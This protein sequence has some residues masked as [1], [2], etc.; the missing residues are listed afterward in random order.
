MPSVIQADLLK[1]ASSSKTLATLSSSAVTLH[2][3]VTVPASIGGSIHYISKA[4]ASNSASI[5][6]TSGITSSFKN[7]KFILNNVLPATDNVNF[8]I[9]ISFDGGSSY[10]TSGYLTTSQISF[11]GS[12]Q[13]H[14]YIEANDSL[15]I[16]GGSGASNVVS[17]GGIWGTLILTV[18]SETVSH[19]MYGEL[20]Y[21]NHSSLLYNGNSSGIVTATSAINAI[22]FYFASGNITSGSIAMYGIKDA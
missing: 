14:S 3:D 4:T 22:K 20:T 9:Q 12:S 21:M 16:L 6:F 2:T 17:E 15:T 19:R 1:D 7:Y 18:P 13:G 5:E 11:H 8:K 10:E